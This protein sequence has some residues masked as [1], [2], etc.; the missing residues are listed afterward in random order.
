MAAPVEVSTAL[1]CASG[2]PTTLPPPTPEDTRSGSAYGD[3]STKQVDEA[4]TP[5][6]EAEKPRHSWRGEVTALVGRA[7]LAVV[8]GLDPQKHGAAEADF[9]RSYQLRFVA[10]VLS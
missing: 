1:P 9:D 5:G 4:G 3:L 7:V 10:S 6:R 2:A 8:A